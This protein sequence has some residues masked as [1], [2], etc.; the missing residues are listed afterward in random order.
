MHHKDMEVWKLS[1]ELVVKIYKLTENFPKDEMF[2]L[3]SQ[4]R[5]CA[6]SIPSNI[7]EGCGRF[8]NKETLRFTS[9]ALGSLA[10]LETQILIATELNFVNNTENI[11]DIIKKVNAL[12]IGLKKYLENKEEITY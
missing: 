6:V 4:I 5:R 11:T 1:M 3:T 7:A 8:S 12:L 10:E 2:G 9:I